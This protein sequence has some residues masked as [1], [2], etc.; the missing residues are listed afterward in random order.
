MILKSANFDSPSVA[1]SFATLQKI[2]S[3]TF[4]T[5]SDDST[6]NHKK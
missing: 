6:E 1:A 2:K 3:Y 4:S 5:S